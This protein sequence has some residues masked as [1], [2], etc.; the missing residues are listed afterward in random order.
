MRR[1]KLFLST[2]V[3]FAVCLTG[4]TIVNNQQQRE[5]DNFSKNVEALTLPPEETKFFEIKWKTDGDSWEDSLY[6]YSTYTYQ[7]NCMSGGNK[8]CTP[9]NEKHL[10]K[11]NKK[12]L[13]STDEICK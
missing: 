5:D 12:T 13:T 9:G 11:I 2:I 1:T 3:L 4:W 10:V 7:I 6:S 8:D